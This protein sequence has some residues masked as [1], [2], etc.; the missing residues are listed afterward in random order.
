[1]LNNKYLTIWLTVNLVLEPNVSIRLGVLS[2][3][4]R[5]DT[6]LELYQQAVLSN[7]S[8]IDF[9]AALQLLGLTNESDA[10]G[11]LLLSIWN[12][13]RTI[14]QANIQRSSTSNSSSSSTRTT[15]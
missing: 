13:S 4:F 9:T 3:H 12:Q 8:S 15:S 10:R 6:I 5:I 11:L 14:R 7:T 2:H 1:M